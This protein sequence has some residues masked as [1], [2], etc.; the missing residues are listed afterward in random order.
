[1]KR[2]E[3]CRFYDPALGFCFCEYT[4]WYLKGRDPE[5]SACKFFKPLIIFEDEQN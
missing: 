1:M 3:A 5:D 2:C 4:N